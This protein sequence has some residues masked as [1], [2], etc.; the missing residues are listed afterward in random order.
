M[1]NGGTV[2]GVS[3]T[4]CTVWGNQKDPIIKIHKRHLTFGYDF[5]SNGEG[6]FVSIG[7]A[8]TRLLPF[9]SPIVDAFCFVSSCL[10]TRIK[11]SA[12]FSCTEHRASVSFGLLRDLDVDIIA[13]R[14]ALITPDPLNLAVLLW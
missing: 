4:A 10:S 12:L 14:G 5:I 3:P 9:V 8:T 1:D 13:I 11:F 7:V 6:G 2:M